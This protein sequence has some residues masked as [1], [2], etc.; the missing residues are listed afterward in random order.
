MI[1]HLQADQAREKQ[2]FQQDQP[3]KEL[4]RLRQESQATNA[5]LS[6]AAILVEQERRNAA[7][8]RN[9]LLEEQQR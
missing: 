9:D 4:Q 8:E 1:A 5:E 7:A 3:E 2:T 6:R